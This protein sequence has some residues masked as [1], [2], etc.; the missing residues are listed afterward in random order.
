M[1]PER[2][3]HLTM[4]K[5]GLTDEERAI[6]HEKRAMGLRKKERWKVEESEIDHRSFSRPK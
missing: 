4:R 5:D 3:E 2:N 6:D 1:K